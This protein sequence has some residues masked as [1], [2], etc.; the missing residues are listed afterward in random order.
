[1]VQTSLA[2]YTYKNFVKQMNCT[3]THKDKQNIFSIL[4]KL[5]YVYALSTKSHSK[6]DYITVFI[7]NNKNPSP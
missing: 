1:M 7:P 4:K 2:L 5:P 3:Y 6:N